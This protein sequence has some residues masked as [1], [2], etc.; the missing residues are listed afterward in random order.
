MTNILLVNPDYHK[1]TRWVTDDDAH[2]QMDHDMLPLGL[3]TVAALT[4]EEYHVD[5]WD[6]P[7]RG[8]ITPD[9]RFEREYALAGITGYRAHLARAAEVS[10]IL[11][12]RG[13]P[14]A[15]GGPGVSGSPDRCRGHFDV[16]FIG[17]AELTWP[18]F[19]RD[20]REGAFR[21]EYRQ[22]EKPDLAESPV[23]RWDS[24]AADIPRYA[25]GCV[26]TTRGC[27]FDC[28]FCDVI[29]LYG[30][31]QRHKPIPRVL[32]EVRQ[33]ESLGTQSIFICDDEFVGNPRYAKDLLRALIPVNNSFRRPLTY[34]TQMTVNVC[35]DD[36]LLELLADANFY[37]LFVGL[38]TPNLESLRETS[39]FQNLR[40]D[41][42]GDVHKI[43][44][45]GMGIRAG[46]IVGFDHDDVSI[47]D[48]QYEFIQKACLPSVS[49]NM[50]KVAIGTR[51]WTRLRREGRVLDLTK[52]VGEGLARVYTNIIPKQMTRVELMTGFRRLAERVY[53]W[54]S[55]RDRMCG[56]VSLVRRP[57]RVR[58]AGGDLASDVDHLTA[59]LGLDAAGRQAVAD[60]TAH[61]LR[62]APFM[63]RRVRELIIQQARYRRTVGELLR[64][65]DR[66]VEVEASGEVVFL[67]D[68]RP[69]PIPEAFRAAFRRIF[70]DVH[71]RVWVN[72]T[73]KS[74]VPEALVSVF[75]D[76]LVRWGDDFERFEP[77]HQ[78]FLRELCERACAERNGQAPETFVA[79]EPGDTPVPDVKRS[80]LD[81]DVLKSVDQKLVELAL[82]RMRTDH[83]AAG[84][85][86]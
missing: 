73:D 15:V 66:Q 12:A 26:Q 41:L 83:A 35:K 79:V 76:F 13:I 63:M 21:A 20:W 5:I 44:S 30:R 39:K 74:K 85:P 27:P 58:E 22:I 32:E 19:L 49:L 25:M 33:L 47:F 71:A 17:E 86:A 84:V 11:R 34:S 8:R 36:E 57:P 56:W 67:P 60:I 82:G 64:Q 48:M 72:L 37:L 59:T 53:S 28:E 70:P 43:L 46:T 50:L 4:P 42:L 18:Q 3:A 24:I 16:L 55:F 23:P 80:R 1:E 45:Y 51:L 52:T 54:E 65:M 38:E 81:D 61:T 6:E 75:L 2:A 31:R 68:E 62:V 69:V 7:V 10:R 29:Y 40:R 77:Y 14:T 9:T 78:A